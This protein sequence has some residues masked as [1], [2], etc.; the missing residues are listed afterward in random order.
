MIFNETC[1]LGAM[2]CL[3]WVND[4]S[5]NDDDLSPIIY[6]MLVIF[7]YIINVTRS[8][9]DLFEV[10][11]RKDRYRVTD[12]APVTVNT[13][14]TDPFEANDSKVL[15]KGE[16]PLKVRMSVINKSKNRA[17]STLNSTN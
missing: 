6:I 14:M 1:I 4:S 16:L 8:F 17:G 9:F 10:C 13:M 2:V 11:G 15:M 3:Y 12:A 5:I 7:N